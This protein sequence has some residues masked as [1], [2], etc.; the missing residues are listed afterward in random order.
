MNILQNP[1][2]LRRDFVVTIFY[3]RVALKWLKY[4]CTVVKYCDWVNL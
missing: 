2:D 4:Y 3:I 1:D